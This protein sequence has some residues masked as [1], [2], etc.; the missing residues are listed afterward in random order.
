MSLQDKDL[1]ILLSVVMDRYP[2]IDQEIAVMVL[3]S[4]S[5][6]QGFVTNIKYMCDVDID[7]KK[8]LYDYY[9]AKD[10]VKEKPLD[11]E[12]MNGF[13]K[14]SVDI[15]HFSK[16]LESMDVNDLISDSQ[17]VTASLD[18][19][20]NSNSNSKHSSTHSF[21][22]N[23]NST[24]IMD[25]KDVSES[26]TSNSLVTSS[27]KV[28]SEKSA[29]S[30]DSESTSNINP[31][32]KNSNKP[33]KM[34]H[35]ANNCENN[36]K[37]N[38]KDIKNV[39]NINDVQNVS[40]KTTLSSYY[41]ASEDLKD[42]NYPKKPVSPTN[43]ISF[44]SSAVSAFDSTK[45][46]SDSSLYNLT[47]DIFQSSRGRSS[48]QVSHSSSQSSTSSKGG[49]YS[50]SQQSEYIRPS[51]RDTQFSDDAHMV[52][53]NESSRK[54]QKSDDNHL[55]HS[56]LHD[57]FEASS[58]N[59]SYSGSP[60]YTKTQGF[61]NEFTDDYCDENSSQGSWSDADQNELYSF[62]DYEEND[63]T[64][65]PDESEL[66]ISMDEYQMYRELLQEMCPNAKSSDVTKA[67]K[68]SEYDP[69]RASEYLLN[70]IA[71][72]DIEEPETSS[73]PSSKGDSSDKEFSNIEFLSASFPSVERPIIEAALESNENDLLKA[74]DDLLAIIAVSEDAPSVID[75]E[76]MDPVAF[77][78]VM[79][80][81]VSTERIQQALDNN[82]G[83][84]ILAS[85]ELLSIDMLREAKEEMEL[86][87]HIMRQQ[88]TEITRMEREKKSK[89]FHTVDG[90]SNTRSSR[91]AQRDNI[92]FLVENYCIDPND[93]KILYEN[94]DNS[95]ILAC[96][97]LEGP[98][99]KSHN[100]WA[101]NGGRKL[102][103]LEMKVSKVKDFGP[104]V[105]RPKTYVPKVSTAVKSTNSSS[106]SRDYPSS[107]GTKAPNRSIS[108][109][110]AN[111]DHRSLQQLIDDEEKIRMDYIRSAT[112]AYR[113]AKANP[114]YG[115][116]A[117]HYF[118]MAR[119]QAISNNSRLQ[120]RFDEIAA[121][122]TQEYSIDLHHL[123]AAYA[124]NAAN[125]KLENWWTRERTLNASSPRRNVKS[126]RIITGAGTHSV[127]GVP[128]IKNG[129]RKMLA[130]GEWNFIEHRAHF[131]VLG[132]KRKDY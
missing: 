7:G 97:K 68:E 6:M 33:Q 105:S 118:S 35:K 117:S 46:N 67:L 1:K 54:P 113:K 11:E 22:S 56:P 129:I 106:G 28:L 127:D 51:T 66:P 119:Q 100:V 18:S 62:V 45:I 44:D 112:E 88:E 15:E 108:F 72:A 50:L 17:N 125:S 93:A 32:N 53:N 65:L 27:F 126:L 99:Y 37:V 24:L 40:K 107:N 60:G 43:D 14:S 29:N 76:P 130:E 116:V 26:T 121:S 3:E 79:F 103:A 47:A 86:H 82:K 25:V 63:T 85:D 71:I 89:Q 41:L 16:G 59:F 95:L 64:P 109:K 84:A 61:Q 78:H 132:P 90:P 42:A 74:T 39:R 77:L 10:G 110:P 20:A 57:S 31:C 55:S 102:T 124:V 19:V 128:R 120:A 2:I 23:S 49:K 83:D 5:D 34:S 81:D 21:N 58:H 9:K 111:S 12:K 30:S 13:E 96:Q 4:M 69:S 52:V 115:S 38:A 87:K 101:D 122:Q 73:K 91:R 48:S 92:K 98:N 36:E 131:D 114:L 8:I 104:T 80:D 94:C 123:S 70:L 75:N